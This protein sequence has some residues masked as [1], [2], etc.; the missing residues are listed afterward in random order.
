[1]TKSTVARV[2]PPPSS[3]T[4]GHH[5]EINDI[6]TV[7]IAVITVKPSVYWKNVVKITNVD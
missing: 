3:T 1:M 7:S 5:I 2:R 6:E 4:V